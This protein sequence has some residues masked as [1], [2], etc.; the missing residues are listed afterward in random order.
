MMDYKIQKKFNQTH[1][2]LCYYNVL[3]L[4]SWLN[5]TYDRINIVKIKIAFEHNLA[6]QY[7]V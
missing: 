4:V 2:P 1:K 6:Q 5:K 3:T 7:I